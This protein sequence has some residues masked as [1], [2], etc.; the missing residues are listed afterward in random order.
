VAEGVDGLQLQSNT[1]IWLSVSD[2][3]LLNSQAKGRLSRQ[4]QTKTVQ[5]YLIR[6]AN[7][8][9]LTQAGRL[10]TDEALLAESLEHNEQKVAA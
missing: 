2:N 9:E 7:T 5:R 10:A 1:E 8:I 4:G 6:A 3:R